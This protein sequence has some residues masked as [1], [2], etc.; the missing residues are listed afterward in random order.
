MCVPQQLTTS[1]IFPRVDFIAH[2]ISKKNQFQGIYS[3][4]FFK[5][6]YNFTV[7]KN[8]MKKIYIYF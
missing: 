7:L 1:G 5:Y 8:F 3:D 6:V 2:G 4:R